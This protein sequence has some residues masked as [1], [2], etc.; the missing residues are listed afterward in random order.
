M[1]HR[2]GS[3][4]LSRS[5]DAGN[6]KPENDNDDDYSD[7]EVEETTEDIADIAMVPMA[8]SCRVVGFVALT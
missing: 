2:M 7:D 6:P 8:G 4:I 1:Y 3:L 5:F